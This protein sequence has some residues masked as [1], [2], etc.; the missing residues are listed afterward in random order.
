MVQSI[1]FNAAGVLV[2]VVY[3]SLRSELSLSKPFR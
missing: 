1:L 3:R 2:L